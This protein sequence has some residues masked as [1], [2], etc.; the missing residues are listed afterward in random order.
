MT[1]TPTKTRIVAAAVLVLFAAMGLVLA[2]QARAGGVHFDPESPAGKE[3]ALPLQQA[4]NEA[5]GG[6]G[7][8]DEGGGGGGTGI[9]APLFGVG[10]GGSQAGPKSEASAGTSPARQP[11]SNDKGKEKTPEGESD[12]STV[13]A[14]ASAGNSYPAGQGLLILGGFLLLGI[15]LGLG[16]RA[17]TRGHPQPS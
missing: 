2:A 5:L 4:R 17:W 6:P 8:G 3:Y 7:K 12:A 13:K 10:V 16:V 11:G 9:A 14:L 15:A 1:E